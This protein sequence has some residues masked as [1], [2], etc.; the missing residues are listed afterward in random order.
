ME[1]KKI[2]KDVSSR[3]IDCFFIVYNNLGFGY[4]EKVYENAMKIELKAL[5]YEV[6]S[7]KPIKVKY[8]GV[9]V[10]DY[11]ADLY[12]D[13]LVIVEIKTAAKL[14]SEH[15]SQLI[16]YLASTHTGHGVLLNFGPRPSFKRMINSFSQQA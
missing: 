7:Q 13:N 6:Q 12:V 2:E 11:Y 8:K 5:G 16:N 15:E 9:E 1:E 4:L 10:G 3:I 14:T